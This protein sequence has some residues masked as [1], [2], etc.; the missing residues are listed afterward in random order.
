[1]KNPQK[2]L[3]LL[4][5]LN[6]RYQWIQLIKSVP[7]GTSG[8][9][10]VPTNQ[11]ILKQF[12]LLTLDD[13]KHHAHQYYKNDVTTDNVPA[14]GNMNIADLT[15]GTDNTHKPLFFNKEGFTWSKSD[16]TEIYDYPTL[17]WTILTLLK[18][19]R[20]V[21]VQAIIKAIKSLQL[22]EFGNDPCKM[23]DNMEMKFN[24]I[25]D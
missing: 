13:M 7:D 11:D 15:P 1:M 12:G 9:A 23:L 5:D 22:S 6:V 16:S 10:D 14:T 18:L 17:I 4:E 20:N 2:I 21:G 19:T 3:D 24:Q 25:K 8:G